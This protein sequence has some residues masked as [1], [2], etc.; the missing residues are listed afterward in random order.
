MYD[1][2]VTQ[3]SLP[4]SPPPGSPPPKGRRKRI[5]SLFWPGFAGGF[6]LL[7]LLS[8]GGLAMT[9]GLNKI[10]LADL[11]SNGPMW[12]PAAITPTP[13]GAQASNTGANTETNGG[14]NQSTGAFQAG[15]VVRNLATSRVNVRATPGYQGKPNGD[16]LAQLASGDTVQIVGERTIA[17]NLIW[18]H[19]NYKGVEGWV[20]EA[21]A[22][23]VQILGK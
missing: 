9:L 1:P 17:D 5:R 23:G 14:G 4:A 11:Q 6:L 2:T 8:C 22:S 15:D 19:I 20:A 12:T 13:E 21:T 3:S 16:I 18:W 10:D 7:S